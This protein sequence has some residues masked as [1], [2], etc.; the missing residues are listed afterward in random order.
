MVYA[1]INPKPDPLHKVTILAIKHP[2][3]YQTQ[4]N[5]K[6][7]KPQPKTLI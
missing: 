1:G 5:N 6:T 2:D 4:T 7:K 3:N